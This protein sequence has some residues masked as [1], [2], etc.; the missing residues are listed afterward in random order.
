MQRTTVQ[1]VTAMV[2]SMQILD[3]MAHAKQH[4]PAPEDQ[5][6]IDQLGTT[7]DMQLK[8]L[9]GEFHLTSAAALPIWQSGIAAGE[10][11][12]LRAA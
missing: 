10:A 3:S 6:L 1:L 2:A 12:L 9:S 5:P 11:Y 7:L 4:Q 8:R